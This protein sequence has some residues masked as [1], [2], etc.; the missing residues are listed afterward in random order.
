MDRRDLL[1]TA[2]ALGV[3][4]WTGVPA[5]VWAQ[6][7]APSPPPAPS[8]REVLS[9]NKGW[10]FFDGDI[11]P[12]NIQGHGWTYANAKAGAAQGGA[13]ASFDDSEWPVVDLPHDF[14]SFRPIVPD[15]NI[16]QGY[17][18][19]GVVWYRNTLRF[20]HADRGKHVE[21]QLDGVSTLATVWIN[22]TLVCHNY[23][24][25]SSAYIDLT[26]YL[27]YGDVVNSLV[28]R[29]D[30]QTMQG[31]WYEGGGIYRNV[32]IVKRDATHIV[33]DGVF[34]HP[35]KD[36]TGWL[37]PIE[38]TLNTSSPADQD[39]T[40][41]SELW[42]DGPAPLARA[43]A[44]AHVP[45]L[46]NAVVK[47][48]MR[49]ADPK[50]WSVEAPN[51]YRVV[52]RVVQGGVTLDAVTTPCG[53]RT[54]HFDPDKGFFLNGQ[55]L[56]IQGVCMHQ[57]H[58]GVGVAV[59]A[60]LIEFRLR[61]LKSLGC[62]AI[63]CSH[64]AQ[65]KMFMDLCD[66]L[67]LLIMDE[68]RLFNPS[69]DYLAQLTWLVRRDRNH[70]C[71]IL[72]S[73]FNEEPMQGTEAGYEMV[74]RMREAVRELDVTRPVIAAMNSSYYTPINVSQTLDV[75]GFNYNQDQYD[76]FHKLHPTMPLMSSEDTSAY[77]TR[78]EY[79]DDPAR[80]IVASYDDDCAQWGE[81]HRQAWKAIH[82]R[83]FIAGGFVW[84]GFDYHGEP[85]PYEF[86]SNSSLFGIFDLCGY[87][88]T[89][90]QIHQAQWVT[91]RP[92]LGLSPH[93]NWSGREGQPI[94]I[95]AC[96]NLD[97]VEVLV[98]G[99]SLG[100]QTVDYYEMN[101]WSAPYQP[102][103]VDLIGY[104]AGHPVARTHVETA[105]PAVRLKLTPDRPA[106]KG[107]GWD[108]QPFRIEAVDD[109]G[110]FAPLAQNMVTF[111]LAGDAEIIGLGNGDPTSLEPEKGDRRSLF[112]GLAQVIVRAKEGSAGELVLT[113]NADGLRSGA[114][115][116][117][118]VAAPAPAYQA[119][120]PP[121]QLVDGWL[122]APASATAPD[123]AARPGQGDM[124]SWQWF[125]LGTM[126]KPL[127][128]PGY[129]LVAAS[130]T[131]YSRVQRQGGTAAFSLITGACT[132]YV[133]GQP[134][135]TKT[136]P[137]PA[138]FEGRFPPAQGPR[139]I[140]VVFHTAAGERFGLGEV[141]QIRG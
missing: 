100:R 107:D 27:T 122:E 109:K 126:L 58:A 76:T 90:F 8:P 120:T 99:T 41:I 65:D 134:I 62:N 53:F 74:R 11:P 117:K 20:D 86:P 1:K 140:T 67:G 92:V 29:V 115:K 132:V 9:L 61:K 45:T 110:R 28:V 32:W 87:E 39:V 25:Y 95:M 37:I 129:S 72:W 83:P 21:L 104:K 51:L 5:G 113:A 47:A 98:N 91:D 42:G 54:Q 38:V 70:P 68:N 103:R 44:P 55:P 71:V 12:P 30:A 131:P 135:G 97:E 123:P 94:K 7:L 141:V 84:T 19:R 23:S 50:L 138:P 13:A 108:V 34:A 80:H 69:P 48:Q 18:K 128:Q 127:D 105:G 24:G 52:T 118:I 46:Q 116:V 6:D 4:G 101:T 49:V 89:A 77:M 88:K 82:E 75:M 112:N 93:W 60:A 64:N 139:R 81:H 3:A 40:V 133:D 136:D 125:P 73:V 43:E 119:T 56:K 85:T 66:R 121:T 36:Q 130:F 2:G 63:R 14:V 35:I 31:W 111:T 10:R 78:G 79:Y 57:D 59:P 124:N 15:A 106:M 33:T 26:P 22:G 17:R 16:D 102:G 137:A 96:S 114:A